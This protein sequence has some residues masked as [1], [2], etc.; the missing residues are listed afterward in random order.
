MGIVASCSQLPIRT[1]ST[2]TH[3]HTQ[4]VLN[5]PDCSDDRC[6]LQA[7][8]HVDHK[9]ANR[10]ARRLA[11]KNHWSLGEL[12]DG[13]EFVAFTFATQPMRVRRVPRASSPGAALMRKE[14]EQEEGMHSEVS[15]ETRGEDRIV[16]ICFACL[17]C[18]E[19]L[20]DVVPANQH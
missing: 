6:V 5:S 12:Q 1:S 20:G 17:L 16:A 19:L 14:A 8:F 13:E 18:C 10:A 7:N 11:Q 15:E 2:H 3:K 9:E 4:F